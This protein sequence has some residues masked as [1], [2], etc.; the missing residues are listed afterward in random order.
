ML[1]KIHQGNTFNNVIKGDFQLHIVF[2]S[3]SALTA[4]KNVI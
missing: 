3:L 1:S 2:P 4:I